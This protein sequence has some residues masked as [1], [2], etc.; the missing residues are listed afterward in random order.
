MQKITIGNAHIHNY[1]FEEAIEWCIDQAKAKIPSYV[2]TANA[3]HIVKL[4]TDSSFQAAYNDDGLVTCDG[5]PLIWASKILRTPIINKITGSDLMP[6]L[7]EAGAKE[8]LKFAIIGGP[9]GTAD[10]AAEKLS[11]KHPGINFVYSYCPPLGFEHSNNETEKMIEA[12]KK[13]EADIIFVGVGAPKQE[14]WIHK[15]YRKANKGVFLGIGAS[16]EFCAGTLNR[17]P[18]WMQ[19]VG[20][21]WFYRM[22]KDPKRLTKRYL[23]DFYFF[24]IIARQLFKRG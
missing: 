5:V 4:E 9:P 6:R 15:N 1:T 22:L 18:M 16:I 14:L 3:D 13:S 19:K 20:L 12:L 23:K 7:C 11:Q 2:V 10:L 8:N 21:E 17:A 24:V